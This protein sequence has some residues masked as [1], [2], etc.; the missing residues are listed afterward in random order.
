VLVL[1]D[2]DE[3]TLSTYLTSLSGIPEKLHLKIQ[4]A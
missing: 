3:D 2:S 4:G 1:K